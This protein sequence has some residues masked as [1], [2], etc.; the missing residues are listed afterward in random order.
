MLNFPDTGTEPSSR[1]GTTLLGYPFT[2]LASNVQTVRMYLQIIMPFWHANSLLL[3]EDLTA[4]LQVSLHFVA[5]AELQR[6]V[7]L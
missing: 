6:L 5:V 2:I 3:E 1:N 7:P 4:L